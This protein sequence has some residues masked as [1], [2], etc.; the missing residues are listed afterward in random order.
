[1]FD[2]ATFAGQLEAIAGDR[3]ATA[4][5]PEV[6]RSY[7]AQ[8]ASPVQLGI[9]E[10]A[11]RRI[12][13]PVLLVHGLQDRVIP[14]EGS[15]YLATHLPDVRLHVVGRCGHWTQI[16]HPAVFHRLLDGFLQGEL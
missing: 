14:V 9:P 15:Y 13:H 5:R 12:G 3:Y 10:A 1:V 7:E 16:E 2:T 11:L 8:F 4:M 6:R